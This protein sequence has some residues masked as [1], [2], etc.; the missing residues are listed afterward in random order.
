MTRT[1]IVIQSRL[2]SSRLPGKA[3]LPIVGMPL[4]ELVAR[5]ASRSGHEV[6]VATSS[7]PLDS[8][9]SEHLTRVG[10]ACIRGALD[11]V[12]GRFVAATED[13][14]PEDIVVRLTG[15]NPVVDADLVDELM[16][17][18]THSQLVYGRVDITR[19]PEGLGVEI[20]SVEALR[21]AN[22]HAVTAY[23]R[24]H[25]TPW[26]RR[27]FSELLFVPTDCPPD[28][29]RFRC[30]VDVLSD[31]DRV[32]TL[33]SAQADPV[34]VPWQSL[35]AVMEAEIDGETLYLPVR[36]ATGLGQAALILNS[37]DLG[38][39]YASQ[40]SGSQAPMIRELLGAAV[41][42]GVTHVI[43]DRADTNS[44]RA[45]WAGSEPA[46]KQRLKMILTLGPTLC[47]S[48]PSEARLATLGVEASLERSFAE[49]GRRRADVVLFRSLRDAHAGGGAAW[50]RLQEYRQTN[51]VSRIG[52]FV[53][54][55]NDLEEA[56]MLPDIGYLVMPIVLGD[57]RWEATM[58]K[59][60][61][62]ANGDIFVAAS[63]VI[64]D[65]IN[66]FRSDTLIA[67]AH[68]FGCE[69]V[70]HLCLAYALGL[71]WV[72]SVMAK[73]DKPTTLDDYVR[74]ASLPALEPHQMVE[75]KKQMSGGLSEIFPVKHA[76]V[77]DGKNS[78]PG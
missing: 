33:F 68:D 67:L 64:G 50:G 14:A 75:V 60:C 55:V 9:I 11:D 21:L 30:T 40:P 7:E 36:D 27:E 20:F 66:M 78:V 62:S 56:L 5:R 57:D 38:S 65:S 72:S 18:L 3:L 34:A 23:D 52:V 24:E 16:L 32:L 29:Q 41:R 19:A 76:G 71:D 2:N 22:R 10:V 69:S 70:E 42:L 51:S 74:W 17:S 53:A 59:H 73:A 13:L 43:T 4:I 48:M 47:S 15:D 12:L 26:I 54:S 46:L 45:I 77:W 37:E 6:V 25:V 58:A 63:N 44:E 31:Y 61:L 28:P 1:R 39:L 49:L 8:R 35:V